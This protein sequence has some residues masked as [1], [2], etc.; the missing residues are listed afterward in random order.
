MMRVISAIAMTGLVCEWLHAEDTPTPP[1][2]TTAEAPA[3]DEDAAPNAV[4]FDKKGKLNRAAYARLALDS[5]PG[6]VD[7]RLGPDQATLAKQTK[8]S[9]KAVTKS[10]KTD[11]ADDK[12]AAETQ[13]IWM[14]PEQVCKEARNGGGMIWTVGGPPTK[15]GGDFS[16][17]HAQVLYLPE[18]SGDPGVDRI[19]VLDMAHNVFTSR[20]EPTWW[21]GSHPE[22]AVTTPAWAQA[23]G[24][25]LGA[26]VAIAR[27]YGNW[28]NSALI[29]FSSGLVGT[30]GTCTSQSKNPFL[31]LPKGKVPT[32]ISITNKSEFAL[33]TVWDV[34]KLHG[35]IAVIAL[36]SMNKDGLMGLYEWHDQHPGLP[37]VGGIRAM[38][39][40]GFVD[41]PFATPTAISAVGNR[42][43]NWITLGGKNSQPKDV[44]L[45]KQEMRD[46]F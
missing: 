43:S 36:E 27:A 22:P 29:V 5:G 41:L 17:T 7:R 24:G 45:S 15:D 12:T 18:K 11:K 1:P 4:L 30:A 13:G 21:G 42:L 38:K 40:I 16:S 25:Q 34:E 35:Q 9:A 3:T 31:L 28:A 14:P 37:S 23:C 32:A 19:S 8:A 44:D 26:P 39:L 2:A 6:A 20:P 33:I 46:G 10:A